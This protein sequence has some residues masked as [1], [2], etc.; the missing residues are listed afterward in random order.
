MRRN[1]KEVRLKNGFIFNGEKI[2]LQSMLNKPSKNIKENLKQAE[3]LEQLGCHIIRVS[4]P[5]VEDVE[6][7]KALKKHVSSPIVADVHFN[8]EIAIEAV[9]NGADKIR[10]NPGNITKKENLKK[11]VDVCKNYEVPIRIGVNSGSLEKEFLKKGE[12]IG[13]KALLKS[14]LKNVSLFEEEFNFSNIVV[15]I[16]SSNVLDVV[17]AC[18]EFRKLKN[19]PLHLGVTEA[20]LEKASLVKSSIAIGSLLLDGIGETI[21]V[22]I[23][24]EPEKEIEAAKLILNALNIEKKGVEIISCP[25]CGRTK[26][27]ILKIAKEVE[28]KLKGCEKNLKIAIM[29]CV[30]NGPGEAKECDIGIAGGNKV[31]VLFKKGEVVASFKEEEIVDVLLKEIE[32]F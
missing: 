31:A 14:A 18:R 22:S 17:L 16:K 19:F 4:V 9:K 15:S 30:V 28:E 5:S 2:Y 20:G 1:L 11:I 25:T 32:K 7:I 8:H 12:K 29:G 23:T 21:R 26:I 24:G 10:I 27:N 13:Y 6:L 3:V